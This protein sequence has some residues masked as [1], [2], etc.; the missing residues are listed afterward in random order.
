MLLFESP[1]MP[2]LPSN[3]GNRGESITCTAF[4]GLGG[5]RKIDPNV[6][7]PDGS[8]A[9]DYAER[10]LKV[11]TSDNADELKAVIELLLSHGAFH[12]V[13]HE[14]PVERDDH[15]IKF[16]SSGDGT[17]MLKAGSLRRIVERLTAF[18]R[19]FTHGA[20]DDRLYFFLQHDKFCKP[21]ELMSLIRARLVAVMTSPAQVN[22]KDSTSLIFEGAVEVLSFFSQW[23]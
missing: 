12:R 18:P 19:V 13:N 6:R 15:D 9:L 14:V 11:T 1:D 20:E 23:F 10:E 8:T 2:H 5:Y 21:S 22:E 3:R 7:G 4:T 16:M 17:Y